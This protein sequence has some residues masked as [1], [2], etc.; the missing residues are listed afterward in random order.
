[1]NF[2]TD[3]ALERKEYIRK[4]ELDGIKEEIKEDYGVKI[5]TIT[6]ENEKG[7]ILKERKTI[8]TYYLH[9]VNDKLITHL[10]R[11]P[12]GKNKIKIL[13]ETPYG[14]RSEYIE[15]IIEV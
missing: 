12:K 7:E 11:L 1:M 6:V 14:V 15:K 8:P 10:G 3:L 5:T 13:A 9:K 2:R 4:E